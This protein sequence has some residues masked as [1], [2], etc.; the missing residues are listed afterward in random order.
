MNL[1]SRLNSLESFGLIRLAAPQ[2]EV[3]YF[4]R[5]ALV[6]DVAYDSLLKQDRK[7]LHRAVGEALERIYPDQLE[8]IASTLAYHFEKAAIPDKA[9]HYLARAARNAAR[10]FAN[11]EALSLSQRGLELLKKLP[12]T[13]DRRTQEL[14]FLLTLAPALM[15]AKG[16]SV[17]EVELTYNRARELCEE[18]GDD[19]SLFAVLW[20]L[21]FF[22]MIRA[23]LHTAHALA[24][25]LLNLAQRTGETTLVLQAHHALGVILMDLGNLTVALEHFEKGI[26]LYDPQHHRS[27]E[28]LYTLD[29]GIA[30]RCFAARILW[31]LGYPDRAVER[32][33]EALALAQDLSDPQGRSFSL[34][35]S[36]IVH[37]FRR[38]PRKTQEN[39]E[40]II[41]LATELGLVQ[42][43]V[44]G[45]LMRGWAVAEQGRLEEGIAQMR[46]S[47]AAYRAMGS[48]IARALFVC[49]L[50]GALGKSG[51]VEEALEVTAEAL[52]VVDRTS[53]R[54]YEAEPYRLK[55]E[56]LLMEAAGGNSRASAI[57]AEA[58]ASSPLITEAESCF[59]KALDIARRQNAKS[60][61][62]RAA[63]SLSRL[64][65]TQGKKEEARQMLSEI[66]GWFTEG[67]DTVDLREAKALLEQLW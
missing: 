19:R 21:F 24:E 25:R 56:L 35:L 46:Q 52:A 7:E 28:F 40:K 1:I 42:D 3:E 58:Y 53:E 5:H 43:Q 39:A 64:W 49:L 38:E 17:P 27:Y 44:W 47:L 29:P 4:F 10:A 13:S 48:E 50:V 57:K 14:M 23:D 8:K 33:D 61:E 62:L 6:Q 16:W 9:I 31:P 41:E 60:W 45:I 66:Y 32:I 26:A 2:K 18:L 54:Y 15:A 37:Q 11:Q 36:A 30:C 22:Y 20:G 67:L 55:G 51:Q 59:R 63:V 34:I 12:D 65:K